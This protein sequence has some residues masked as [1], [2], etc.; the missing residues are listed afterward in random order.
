MAAL[1][2]NLATGIEHDDLHVRLADIEDRNAAVHASIQME[3][4][5]EQRRALE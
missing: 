4:F 2:E 5:R 1:S 3:H